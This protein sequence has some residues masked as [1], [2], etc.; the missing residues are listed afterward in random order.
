M[1]VKIRRLADDMSS[2]E[3]T[4]LIRDAQVRL[5]SP[6]EMMA[7]TVRRAPT[8]LATAARFT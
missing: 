7:T 2:K 6:R 3:F 8:C 5:R 1:L 4:K